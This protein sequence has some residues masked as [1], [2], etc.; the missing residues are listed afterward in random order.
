MVNLKH[1]SEVKKNTT[2]VAG[3]ELEVSRRNR[4]AFLKALTDYVG[5]AP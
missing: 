1:V 5:G 2:I 3:N 4:S